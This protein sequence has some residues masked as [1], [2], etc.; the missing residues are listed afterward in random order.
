MTGRR[1]MLYCIYFLLLALSLLIG[2]P[3]AN[4]ENTD[5]DVAACNNIGDL[6]AR[7]AGC[8]RLL[9]RK[10]LPARSQAI[11]YLQRAQGYVRHQQ[12]D[13]AIQDYDASLKR[14]PNSAIALGERAV[15]YNQIG[16]PDHALQS[17]DQAIRL[18]P[19]PSSTLCADA[20]VL[21]R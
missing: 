21:T 2:V 20:H 3:A 5:P 7:I 10:N 14:D 12:F 9:A 4:A 17:A 15:V 1:K 6:D 19:N 16:D 13:R 18:D 8:T 11:L